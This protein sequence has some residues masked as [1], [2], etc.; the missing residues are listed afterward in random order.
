MGLS[1]AEIKALWIQAGGNPQVAG[2]AAAFALAESGGDPTATHVNSNGSQDVGLWQI[3]TT[4]GA[5]ATADPLGNAKSAI[6]ISNN[7]SNWRPW[8][9]AY[10]DGACGQKGGVY[11][12]AMG[13]AASVG[14]F[15]GNVGALPDPSAVL[16]GQI[17]PGAD[18]AKVAADASAIDTT[19]NNIYADIAMTINVILNNLLYGFL[20]LAGMAACIVG[21][22][23]LSKDS[24]IGSTLNAV[25][26]VI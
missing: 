16:S 26:A 14:K 4:H 15:L 10:T 20:A 9:T 25:K 21:V 1:V 13:T 11:N 6:Q 12:I 17:T 23:M 18:P 5:L 8:C 24:V 7:G 3:N 2:I 19:I 22:V